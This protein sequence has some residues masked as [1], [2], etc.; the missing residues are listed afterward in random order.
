M[1]DFKKPDCGDSSCLFAEKKTGMRT[2]GGCR[3]FDHAGFSKDVMK[4][5]RLMLPELLYLRERVKEFEEELN[6]KPLVYGN[7]G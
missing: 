6:P 4:S 1:K 7:K 5:A 2:N 3:C